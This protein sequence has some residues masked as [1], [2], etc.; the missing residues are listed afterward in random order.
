MVTERWV[1]EEK[2]GSA[3]PFTASG[4]CRLKS[5]PALRDGYKIDVSPDDCNADKPGLRN[6]SAN[7]RI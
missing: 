2:S 1:S 5:V 4:L 6:F 7:V 3:A